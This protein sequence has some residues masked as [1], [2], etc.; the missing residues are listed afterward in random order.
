[1]LFGRQ[2]KESIHNKTKELFGWLV[3][4]MFREQI[5]RFVNEAIDIGHALQMVYQEAA[6]SATP[7]A[8]FCYKAK[9]QF[10][11]CR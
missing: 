11:A 9:F 10:Q 6:K 1:M 8:P 5:P 2:Y 4:C 7:R 3:F